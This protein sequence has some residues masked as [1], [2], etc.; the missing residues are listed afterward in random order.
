MRGN[1]CKWC[2]K[3]QGRGVR[4][5]WWPCWDGFNPHRLERTLARVLAGHAEQRSVALRTF[6]PRPDSAIG[7]VA[8]NGT[9]AGSITA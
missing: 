8:G 1:V 2:S 9:G 7:K 5:N 3:K 6:M 4:A